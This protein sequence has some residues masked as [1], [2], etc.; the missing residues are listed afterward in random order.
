MRRDTALL[1]SR[2]DSFLRALEHAAHNVQRALSAAPTWYVAYSAG[3]DSTCVLHLVRSL[4]P[5]TPAVTSVRQW[6][7]PQTEELLS[8]TQNLHPITYDGYNGEDWAVRWKDRAHAEQR[9][10][11]VVWLETKDQIMARG[12]PERGVFL[13]LRSDEAGYRRKHLAV[14]GNLFDCAKS[15]KYHSNPIAHWSVWDVWAYIYSREVDYN[16]AYDVMEKNGIAI[17]DQ[18]IGPFDHALGSGALATIKR[19]WPEHFNR[20]A[21]AHPEARAYA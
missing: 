18:R 15:G 4:A 5:N 3:K 19:C 7:L 17:K 1:H 6:D 12:R 10:P 11:E 21:A 8:R 2:T 13:G 16:R 20:I 14:M 9:H